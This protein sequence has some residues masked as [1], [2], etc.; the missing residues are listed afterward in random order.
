MDAGRVRR[1]ST[2]A[3]VVAVAGAIGDVTILLFFTIGQP[4]GTLNDMSLLVMTAA[5]A[6]VMLGCYELGGVTP[7][8]PARLSLAAGIG[9]IAVWCVIQAALITG[10]VSFDYEHAATGA[11]AIEALML[12]V[13]GA[14]LTGAPLLAGPWLPP[15]LRWLG[16]AGGLGWIGLGLGLLLGGL[17]HPLTYLG[18]V[19]YEIAFPIWAFLLSRRFRQL[20]AGG[21]GR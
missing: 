5:L 13:I 20:L 7:L 10:L 3:M 16:A 11:Y 12:I 4:W 6:P 9:G 19:G 2:A 18:G 8:V 14:W 1:A 17:N 21:P 15:L